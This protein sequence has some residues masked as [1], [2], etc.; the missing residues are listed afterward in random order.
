MMHYFKSHRPGHCSYL[1]FLEGSGIE[2]NL[3]NQ[4]RTEQRLI[5]FNPLGVI[6]K[7]LG[8]QVS[9]QL[10]QL[11]SKGHTRISRKHIL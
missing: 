1:I 8:T 10:I 3:S 4:R 6:G 9:I 7:N 2:K 5:D 11:K